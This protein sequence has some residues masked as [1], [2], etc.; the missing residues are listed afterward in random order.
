MVFRSGTGISDWGDDEES[1]VP[2]ELLDAGVLEIQ[3][4]EVPGSVTHRLDGEGE[5]LL[6]GFRFQAA[7]LPDELQED[8]GFARRQP[9]ARDGPNAVFRL[10]GEGPLPPASRKKHDEDEPCRGDETS[11]ACS[12]GPSGPFAT[13]LTTLSFDGPAECATGEGGH[14]HVI[15]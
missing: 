13:V 11:P 7:E 5:Y 6:L 3:N 10:D 1:S 12:P 15:L 2:V 9:Q 14:F 4:I 8:A